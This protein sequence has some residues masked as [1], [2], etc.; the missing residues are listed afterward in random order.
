MENETR[1]KART[2]RTSRFHKPR[3]LPHSPGARVAMRNVLTRFSTTICGMWGILLREKLSII[4]GS[5]HVRNHIL[6][7]AH[8]LHSTLRARLDPRFCLG[9]R[10][11]TYKRYPGDI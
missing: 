6:G 11:A 9:Y 5:S 7:S 10:F 2:S 3:T 8:F 4:L 1:S